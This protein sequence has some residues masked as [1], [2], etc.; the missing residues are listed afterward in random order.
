MVP[1]AVRLPS[2]LTAASSVTS[3]TVGAP[4]SA[5]SLAPW[6]VNDTSLLV[7]SNDLIVK[8]STL[9][10]L[11]PR[12][13]TGVVE[14]VK[15]EEP[16]AASGRQPRV[17]AAGG[18]VVWNDDWR[19]WASDAERVPEAVRLPAALTAASSVTSCTVGAPISAPSLAPWIVNDTSLLV[20]SNDLIVKVSTLL[21]LAP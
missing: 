15:V 13:W 17:P 10:S 9:L 11:A 7:P 16:S 20:P 1:E 2:A 3:C 5:P 18:T 14:G 6:I 21:S 4:I 12:D 19:W 8:V